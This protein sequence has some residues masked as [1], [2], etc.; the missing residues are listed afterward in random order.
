MKNLLFKT[1]LVLAVLVAGFSV[2]SCSDDGQDEPVTPAPDM[3]VK[4]VTVSY[5]VS[6]A[7]SYYDFFCYK[8]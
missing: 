4:N 6:L 2:A 8:T 7:Q 3:S 1:M 5:S